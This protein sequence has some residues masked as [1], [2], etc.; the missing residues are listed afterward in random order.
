MDVQEFT[1]A[2]LRE[3]C[4]RRKLPIRGTKIE[5]IK[6]LDENDPKGLWRE[7]IKNVRTGDEEVVEGV[8]NG[9]WL[10]GKETDNEHEDDQDYVQE[11]AGES[12]V[13]PIPAIASGSYVSVEENVCTSI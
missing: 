8:A 7:E 6:K 4:K 10:S 12:A 9:N 11:N 1:L 3:M 2:S 13:E 5:L